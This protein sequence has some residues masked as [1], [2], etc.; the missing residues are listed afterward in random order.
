MY[1]DMFANDKVVIDL[2]EFYL[3]KC[4]LSSPYFFLILIEMCDSII[5]VGLLRL[6]STKVVRN[7]EEGKRSL[8]E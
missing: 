8:I 6:F 3:V 2:I 5:H 1:H 4:T 7:C